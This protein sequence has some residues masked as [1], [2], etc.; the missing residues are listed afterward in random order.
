MQGLGFETHVA[1][2]G[3]GKSWG[4]IYGLPRNVAFWHCV[5]WDLGPEQGWLE[6]PA[7]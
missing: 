7:S 1:S 6:Q 4:R 2:C 3:A 5:R